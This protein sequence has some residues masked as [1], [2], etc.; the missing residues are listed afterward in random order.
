MK[1]AKISKL[2]L[3]F[4]ASTL[5]PALLI[6]II[7]GAVCFVVVSQNKIGSI[8]QGIVEQSYRNDTDVLNNLNMLSDM[9]NFNEGYT[10]MYSYMNNIENDTDQGYYNNVVK[11]LD[12]YVQ[13]NSDNI[14]SSW[15]AVFEKGILVTD[16][17]ND[18]GI[19]NVS[20]FSKQPW[21]DETML[22]KGDIFYSGIYESSL[23]D[24]YSNNKVVSMICPVLDWKTNRLLGAYGIEITMN[25][26]NS[27]ISVSGYNDT[28]ALVVDSE[29]D[30]LY[31]KNAVML[32]RHR[33][34]SDIA[35]QVI[36]DKEGNN[37][38]YGGRDYYAVDTTFSTTGWRVIY[39]VGR[40]EINDSIAAITLPLI[41]TVVLAC[42]AISVILLMYIIRFVR[43]LNIVKKNTVGIADGNYD[44]KMQV[45]S[46]DEFGELAVA[47][48]D[49]IDVLKR[50]AER[51][52]VTNIYNISTFYNKAQELVKNN[53][54]ATGKYA[55]I[56]LDIDH[57]RVVNDIYSWQVGDNILRFIANSLLENINKDSI[58]GRMSGDVFV[59]CV[60]YS[61][62][63]EIE[64]MLNRI[65]EDILGYDIAVN[66]TPHFGI[67]LD[68]DKELPLYLMCDRAGIA[69]NL[70]KGNMLA[71]FSYYDM[72]VNRI[73]MDIKFIETSTQAAFE[74]HQFFIQLQ[75]K[76]NMHT[77]AIVGAEALVRW[78][79]PVKG[80]IRPDAFIPVFEKN[81]NI[82]KLDEYVW[83]ETCKCLSKWNK[84]GYNN[85]PVSVNISR[86]HVY[87][88]HLV[89]K[90]CSLVEKY[91]IP[92]EL[93]QLE[94]TESALLEDASELYDLM[95]KL[96]EKNFV[97][98][99]DDFA[100]G[101]SSL[102]TLKSAPFDIVKLDKE[103]ISAVTENKR[104]RML[105]A[106]TISMI[107][108]QSM[109]VV[110]E[111][112]ETE[113]QVD[114]LIE[115]GCNIAQGFFFSKPI[116]VADFEKIAYNI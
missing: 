47:F 66:I 60:K 89:E 46:S 96:K 90:L 112:V 36:D 16:G 61:S 62:I 99:M 71:T 87:N 109:E 23:S 113:E 64:D 107:D 37:V 82:L 18:K 59:M 79:H 76:Y 97:L 83:E 19:I 29:G 21:Y 7:V 30:L 55:I 98:L 116:N 101:Y 57:F 105:V 49:T 69:L 48:N 81:G 45:D 42:I 70:I 85:I 68:A 26:L 51:D 15:L 32:S 17:I 24:K 11:N 9:L 100:S 110:V 10:V 102:N 50:K 80:I 58:C 95:Y 41:I 92:V 106:S 38:T 34:L 94:F 4:V 53:D 6:L 5:I 114:V 22:K 63:P 8:R 86:I 25:Y 1:R 27:F 84:M 2:G 52:G 67:Y 54:P 14:V 28:I 43:K 75:P 91:D 111:G 103:F 12:E 77:N 65:K 3:K 56:R 108:K 35:K 104:D 39:L 40:S 20:D 115:S 72:A 33:E 13:Y 74:E 31:S 78:K 88:K 93:L 44:D 73:N